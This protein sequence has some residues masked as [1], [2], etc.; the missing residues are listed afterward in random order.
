MLTFT[1]WHAIYNTYVTNTAYYLII[2]EATG[3]ISRDEVSQ[4]YV[5]L[6]AYVTEITLNIV[7]IK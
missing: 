4:V 5:H 7:R 3:S 1:A 6:C 2:H